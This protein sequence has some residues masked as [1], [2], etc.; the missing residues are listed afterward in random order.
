MKI[1]EMLCQTLHLCVRYDSH[2]K[3]LILPSTA[4]IGWSCNWCRI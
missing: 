4:L 2:N 1:K 3:H